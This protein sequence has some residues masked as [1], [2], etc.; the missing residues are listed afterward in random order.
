MSS[1]ATSSAR[2]EKNACL[3]L[4]YRP[5]EEY[6]V[7]C[8]SSQTRSASAI[9]PSTSK[10]WEETALLPR[11]AGASRSARVRHAPFF[12][13]HRGIKKLR[14]DLPCSI[15]SDT[16]MKFGGWSYGVL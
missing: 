13:N 5:V 1:A 12:L 14:V 6:S 9:D 2:T 7:N 16:A 4:N 11:S 8:I 15:V 3:A 10:V